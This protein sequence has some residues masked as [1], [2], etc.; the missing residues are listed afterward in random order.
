MCI[1]RAFSMASCF[2]KATMRFNSL[3]TCSSLRPWEL[4]IVRV[5]ERKGSIDGVLLRQQLCLSVVLMVRHY[6]VNL[7]YLL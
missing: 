2:M 1:S 3:L 5:T 6:F 7:G 4:D